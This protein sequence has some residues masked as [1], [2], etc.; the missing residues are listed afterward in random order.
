[1]LL[2]NILC[3]K[4]KDILN[5]VYLLIGHF[6]FRSRISRSNSGTHM[7]PNV[8]LYIIQLTV[9]VPSP[10]AIIFIDSVLQR[11]A[12]HYGKKKIELQI[13]RAT[14]SFLIFPI[15]ILVA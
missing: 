6:Q 5:K 12:V 7:F 8:L 14:F 11:E 10:K 15:C 3:K 2:K 13:R 4:I 9:I 1:M